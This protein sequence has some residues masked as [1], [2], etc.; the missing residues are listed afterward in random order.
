[1]SH[2]C[3]GPAC[4]SNPVLTVAKVRGTVRGTR[5]HRPIRCLDPHVQLELQMKSSF[6]ALAGDGFKMFIAL[7]VALEF[8][9]NSVVAGSLC[10]LLTGKEALLTCGQ[11]CRILCT[12]IVWTGSWKPRALLTSA[13]QLHEKL[14]RMDVERWQAR[15]HLLQHCLLCRAFASVAAAHGH[16]CAQHVRFLQLQ[17][18]PAQSCCCGIPL[19]GVIEKE[20]FHEFAQNESSRDEHR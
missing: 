8:S 17:G 4:R 6:K 1:M 5:V 13:R 15:R 2:C 14:R 3:R 10:K 11:L 16:R 12:S 19:S 18:A 7:V 20:G 9:R